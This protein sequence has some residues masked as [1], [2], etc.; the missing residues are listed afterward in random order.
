MCGWL[1]FVHC[2]LF[3]LYLYLFFGGSVCMS[4]VRFIFRLIKHMVENVMLRMHALSL[5]VVQ[6]MVRM[7]SYAKFRNK[8]VGLE[9][10]MARNPQKVRLLQTNASFR[11]KLHN[12]VSFL[13]STDANSQAIFGRT[14]HKCLMDNFPYCKVQQSN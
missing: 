14:N 12:I 1:S 6:R 9:I 10:F 8:C 13:L 11:A 7:F 4:S 2:Y 5:W 3:T